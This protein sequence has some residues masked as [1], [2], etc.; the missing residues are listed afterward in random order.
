MPVFAANGEFLFMTE[1]RC[2]FIR[3]HPLFSRYSG[4]LE[5]PAAKI[6]GMRFQYG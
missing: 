2:G 1:N 3:R 4:V 5:R 6:K